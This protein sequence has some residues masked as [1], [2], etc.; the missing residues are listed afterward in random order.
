LA[1]DEPDGQK[2]PDKQAPVTAD[3]PVVAQ[4]APGVHGTGAAS[5]DTGQ[6]DAAGHAV[7][8]TLPAA[9]YVPLEHKCC[10]AVLEPVRQ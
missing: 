6:K 9:Q 8:W 7:G 4:N 5:A 1:D 2:C 10:V 3:R